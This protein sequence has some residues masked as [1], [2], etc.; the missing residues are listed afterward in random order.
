MAGGFIMVILGL[1]F[2][3]ILPIPTFLGSGHLVPIFIR[4]RLLPALFQSQQSGAKALLG[5]LVGF[6]PCCLSWAMIV[7]AASEQEIVAGFLTMVAFGLGT[8]PTLLAA[9]LFTSILSLKLRLLGER[10]AAFAVIFMG[11]FL[12][13][14]G[15][16][17]FV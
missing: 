17:I 13:T 11:I 7:K 10:L 1:A 9:G 6:M 5:L 16:G 14:S 3:R 2:L 12:I 8:M 4:H 15:A